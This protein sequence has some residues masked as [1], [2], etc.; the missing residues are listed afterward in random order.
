MCLWSLKQATSSPD[1][2][3]RL[4]SPSSGYSSQSNTPT[5]GTPVPSFMRC[6]SPSGKPK[7]RVPERKSSLLSSVSISSSSTSLS[8]N[9]SDSNRN[10]IPPP[11]P[12][13]AGP[14]AFVP[15]NPPSSPPPLPP[16]LA[17][18]HYRPEISPSTTSFTHNPPS[19]SI[20][21]PSLHQFLPEFPP[22]PPPEV[23]TDPVLLSLNSSFS[24]PPP[25]PPLPALFCTPKSTPTQLETTYTFLCLLKGN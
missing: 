18:V 14:V 9:T 24:P 4:T 22:P 6:M 12:L 10:N 8:S 3:H 20:H 17:C 5:A 16:L 11:P 21:E 15:F 2:V 19:T 13:P 25:P 7:P 1:R 23:L